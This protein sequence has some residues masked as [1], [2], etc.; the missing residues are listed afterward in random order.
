MRTSGGITCGTNDQRGPR[1]GCATKCDFKIAAE[2]FL[3]H[4]IKQR[5]QQQ[6]QQQQQRR[7]GIARRK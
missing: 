6:Q 1:D 4:S 7:R 3:C 5:Q 2:V